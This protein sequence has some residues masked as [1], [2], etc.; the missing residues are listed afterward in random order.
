[1]RRF[2]YTGVIFATIF[3]ISFSGALFFKPSAAQAAVKSVAVVATKIVCQNES[4][5]PNWNAGANINSTSAQNYVNA[6]TNCRLA[7]GWV[8]QWVNGGQANPGDNLGEVGTWNSTAPTGTDGKT[9]F[10]VNSEKE[11]YVREA[12]KSGYIN[13]SGLNGGSESAEMW[14]GNDVMYYDNYDFITGP[15]FGNTYYCVAFNA[16][17]CTDSDQDGYY[18]EGGD[19]GPADCNDNNGAIHPTVTESCNGIDDNC[20]G[21]TDEA[22]GTTPT[23]CGTGA[24][25]ATGELACLGGSMVDSCLVGPSSEEIC[26]NIDDDCD[27]SID[28]DLTQKTTCGLGA[29]AYNTG[30]KTCEAGFWVGDTCDPFFGAQTEDC[31]GSLD[32][33]CDGTA[34]ENCECVNGTNR[35]CGDSDTGECSFGTQTCAGGTW[36]T[37]EG[38]IGRANEA[39]DTKDNDCDASI[40]EDFDN[41]ND[42]C[43]AGIGACKT[44]GYYVCSGDGLT[45]E[46]NATAGTPGEEIC[47]DGIDQN[48]DGADLTCSCEDTDGDLIC[49]NVD[50]CP[51]VANSNQ[52]D[53]D[54]DGL[55][56]SC[57]NCPNNSN[58]DQADSDGDLIGDACDNCPLTRNS[59]QTDDDADGIGNACDQYNCVVTGAEICDQLDNDCDGYVDEGNVCGGGC[60]SGTTLLDAVAPGSLTGW[61]VNDTGN[62]PIF[63]YSEITSPYDLST[64]IQTSVVGSTYALCPSQSIYKTYAVN[65]N[66]ATSDLKAYLAFTSTMDEY[67][68]PYL[69]VTLLDSSDVAV[70][71]QVYYGQGVISGIYAGYAA[72]DPAHYTELSA[73]SGDL[74]LDLAKM[75][76]VNFSKIIVYISNYACIGQNSITFDHLRLVTDCG[77]GPF[78]G[79]ETCNENENCETCASDCGSC[80]GGCT[81]STLSCKD[82]I[83]NDCD[84]AIDEID[85]CIP[86]T[87]SGYKYNDSNNNG[88][89]NEGESAISGWEIGLWRCPYSPMESGSSTLLSNDRFVVRTHDSEETG[90]CSLQATTTT[91]ANGY[92]EFTGLTSGDYGVAETQVSGWAQT[93]PVSNL[94]YYL[95]LPVESIV[96]L[97]NFANYFASNSSS[98]CGNGIKEGSEECDGSAPDG[99]TCE[100]GCALKKNSSGGGGTPSYF[101]TGGGGEFKTNT[102]EGEKPVVLGEEG[103]PI[104]NLIKTADKDLVNPGDEITFT[105][106]VKNTGT[107]TAFNVSLKDLLPEGLKFVGSTDKEMAWNLGDLAAGETKTIEVKT[108][109]KSDAQAGAF[110]NT[111]VVKA[112]NSENVTASHNFEVKNISVLGATGFDSKELSG[113]SFLLFLSLFGIFFIKRKVA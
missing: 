84:K 82:Q 19:C 49:N 97:I 86:S 7:S 90:F 80:G 62:N 12:M 3:N 72:S 44:A 76:N 105:L 23:T 27:E 1:M 88:V 95:N 71:Y 38:V 112:D 18:A 109:V 99:Y 40:D 8:F 33:N 46:C 45:T 108:L 34:D 14:C 110:I 98:S 75:G 52:A 2:F 35:S 79:D 96:G 70:G 53:A 64:A 100:T 106:T 107:L 26:N 15:K 56:D 11:I 16:L 51:N 58:P 29:C 42:E 57:D 60:V 10:T 47:G 25:A 55:G 77:S 39:C 30:V 48:C 103:A 65:G 85:E 68:F 31:E 9:S 81:P 92:Y 73:A 87:I 93:Y 4:D 69:Q 94:S 22:L 66:S 28:E 63:S 6:H 104:L 74:T 43:S 20:N 111:A 24:C 59:E 113:L 32:E 78:C 67:N 41:L 61:N 54:G 5:L 13:Y 83:D 89:I 36:G 101:T 50:N 17:K 91:N 21:F 37:C 102:K